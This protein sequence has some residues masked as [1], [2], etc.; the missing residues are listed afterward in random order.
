MHG[1]NHYADD[2]ARN[3]AILLSNKLG[4]KLY[5]TTAPMLGLPMARQVQRLRASDQNDSVYMP[6][7][8]SLAFKLI[9]KRELTPLQNSIDGT[10]VI[11]IIELYNSQKK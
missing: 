3:L 10:S 8:N 2:Q 1:R 4:E 5:T 6:G 11:R 9:A 7:L